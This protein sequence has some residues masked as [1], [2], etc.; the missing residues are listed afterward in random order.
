MYPYTCRTGHWIAEKKIQNFAS[1]L[2]I[3]KPSDDSNATID[4]IIIAK[5]TLTNL[6]QTSLFIS[7][8]LFKYKAILFCTILQHRN[9]TSTIL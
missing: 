5:A 1:I 8:L 2:L 6:S 9:K 7:L 4:E 3:K